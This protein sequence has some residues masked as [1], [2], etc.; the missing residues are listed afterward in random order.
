MFCGVYMINEKIDQWLME[1]GNRQEVLC[2]LKQPL[3]A[4]QISKK[5]GIPLDTCSYYIAKFVD[6]GLLICLNPNARNSR[7]YWLTKTGHPCRRKFCQKENYTYNEPELPDINWNLYGWLCFNHRS[8]VI[9][10]LTYP[11]QPSEIKRIIR[12]QGSQVK[13]SANNIRDIIKLF[14]A[15]G[16]VRS[17][18]IRKKAHWRYELTPLGTKLR[19]LL[20]QAEAP[21]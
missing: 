6:W 9:K 19:Q 13:I 7:L 18:P 5:T 3:T 12:L 16:L 8:A 2:I 17:V 4:R 1:Q 11:M 15:R 20:V 14:I 21:L 10:I